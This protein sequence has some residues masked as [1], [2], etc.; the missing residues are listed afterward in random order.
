MCRHGTF[1]N[2]FDVDSDV[3]IDVGLNISGKACAFM[4]KV[5]CHHEVFDAWARK[6]LARGWAVARVE[7]TDEKDADRGGIIR[8][9]VTE[10]LTPALD[11][12]LLRDD[13]AS[14]LLA[15]AEAPWPPEDDE[16]G[17]GDVQIGVTMI[18]AAV[19]EIILGSFV[20]GPSRDVLAALLARVEPRE[21]IVSVTRRRGKA[22]DATLA[23]LTKHGRE[24]RDA[25]A[26]RRVERSDGATPDF[27]PEDTLAAVAHFG[28]IERGDGEGDGD[29]LRLPRALRDASPV[30]MESLAYAVR[31]CAWAG[32]A[33]AVLCQGTFRRLVIGD[34]EAP[35]PP[36]E[37]TGTGDDAYD[38]Y[39]SDPPSAAAALAAMGMRATYDPDDA[40]NVRVDAATAASLHLVRGDGGGGGGGGDDA[41]VG[42]LL[43]FLDDTV[44]R[45][46]RR[47][48]RE[49]ILAPLSDAREIARRLDALDAL[50]C[51][52]RGGGAGGSATILEG[53]RRA[54]RAIPCDA[55]R[56]TARA[57]ALDDA[58]ARASEAALAHGAAPPSDVAA[59]VAGAGAAAAAAAAAGRRGGRARLFEETQ[60][61]EED[62]DRVGEAAV[63][64]WSPRGRD[65]RAFVGT[66]D[67]I[68]AT[69][70]ALAELPAPGGG[71]GG[72]GGGGILGSFRELG[73]AV[74]RP[75]KDLRA[76]VEL[77]SELVARVCG[78]NGG[79]GGGGGDDDDA[80]AAAK[81]TPSKR[82]KKSKKIAAL[83]DAPCS[84]LFEEGGP[85]ATFE[86]LPSPGTCETFD[87]AM[88]YLVDASARGTFDDDDDD[89]VVEDAAA[90]AAAAAARE[91]S[92]VVHEFA[93]GRHLWRAVVSAGADLD[94]LQSFASRTGSGAVT[95]PFCRPT[96]LEDD[97]DDGGGGG[98]NRLELRDSWHPLVPVGDSRATIAADD[99]DDATA[100]FV[101]NDVV[102]G[103]GDAPACMLLTGPN[104]GGKSTLLRQVAVA[105]I[106]AQCGCYVPAASASLHVVDAVACR[107]GA[108]DGIASGV[109]TF[110][111]E[112]SETS[113]ALRRA[114]KARSILH[115]SPY[116]RVGV[117]NAVP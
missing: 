68:V 58:C 44:T 35:P 91:I 96:F 114:T 108:G 86:V 110:L 9:E 30:A 109:S 76:R 105:V 95:G 14:Y 55:Q 47:R 10:I 34:G 24:R 50:C 90:A 85:L 42:S 71:G 16:D 66:V 54:L 67:A 72:G 46:G 26:F 116:D 43:A 40:A 69:A 111:A 56:G 100:P 106:M 20:D 101:R 84:W 80:R 36:S 38:D 51:H 39:A 98:G 112:M 17:D 5:G 75:A 103:G 57:V 22:S 94:A 65:L 32:C 59:V 70:E 37:T 107:I 12:G 81:P 62:G 104:M 19:G 77:A 11:R 89:D 52:H 18:D 2:M 49:W 92:S 87:D 6:V 28:G 102:L 60:D 1:Y 82:T 99:A 117:V 31:H 74:L 63:A 97:D 113:A 25:C 4:Q 27:T 73:R 115:W 45:P 41:S 3:G 23:A 61:S 93:T 7:E 8:R 21:V 64:F 83:R 78:R 53:V 15:L 33:P 79:G 13:A 48:L 29:E 88:A